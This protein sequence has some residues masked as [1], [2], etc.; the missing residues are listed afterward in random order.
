MVLMETTGRDRILAFGYHYTS[1][2]SGA[3]LIP[4]F[5]VVAAYRRGVGDSF[6]ISRLLNG[7]HLKPLPEVFAVDNAGSL[8]PAEGDCLFWPG[9]NGCF[10][11][12]W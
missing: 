7:Q 9:Q 4:W 11:A 6:S 5:E 12:W 10:R 3:V 1:P 2:T 8:G